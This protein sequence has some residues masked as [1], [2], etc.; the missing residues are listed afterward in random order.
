MSNKYL[1]VWQNLI[2]CFVLLLPSTEGIANLH[3]SQ[4]ALPI[5]A[6][7]PKQVFAFFVYLPKKSLAPIRCAGPTQLRLICNTF[8][9]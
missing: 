5:F 1:C 9:V 7:L 4:A 6:Y 8:H 3:L 2:S